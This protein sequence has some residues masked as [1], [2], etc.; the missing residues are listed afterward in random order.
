MASFK[1]RFE[2]LL[3]LRQHQQKQIENQIAILN[4]ELARERDRLKSIYLEIEKNN[5]DMTAGLQGRID[6]KHIVS[7]R[8]YITKLNKDLEVQKKVIIQLNNEIEIKK[9]QLIKAMQ[10]VKLLEKLKEKKL[11]EF[12]KEEEFQENIILDEIGNLAYAR[13]NNEH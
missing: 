11:R 2:K 13:R 12:I 4:H 5:N 1:F 8:E 3:N 7:L 9:H 10:K 6:I